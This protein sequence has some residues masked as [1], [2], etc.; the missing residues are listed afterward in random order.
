MRS[1][2]SLAGL[3]FATATIL[4]A[5]GGGG[6]SSSGS[7]SSTTPITA[8]SSA[9]SSAPSNAPSIAPS[10]SPSAATVALSG[11][12]TDFASGAPLAGL[13]VTVGPTPN[14]ST[15][16][17]AQTQTL[18]VCGTVA[19]TTATTTTNANGSF[20]FTSSQLAAGTYMMIVGNAKGSY[21]TLHRTVTITTGT[22]N[23]LGTVKLT[24][25]SSAVQSWLADVNNQR[26]TVSLPISFGNLAV[27]EYLQEEANQ[28]A[29]DVANGTTQYGDSEVDPYN[30]AYAA[31]PG[32]I[33][34]VG[35]AH[36]IGIVNYAVDPSD[37]LE[38]EDQGFM[39]EK[40]SSTGC[41]PYGGNWQTCLA[42]GDP[43]PHYVAMSYTGNVW[44]GLG[45]TSTD[46]ATLGGEPAGILFVGSGQ[47]VPAS[48]HRK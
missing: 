21:A 37:A 43:G 9:A 41:G 20:S 6:G 32:A 19:S 24:A 44:V 12:M 28:W 30:A 17:G 39:S 4:A 29:T 5:C 36:D 10:P 25:L 31:D 35:I 3:L 27:D 48:I 34:T 46:N 33:Y 2:V 1:T 15:C 38:L 22:P 7:G 26:A 23:A 47:N 16:N 13:T 11:T 42:A 18:N 45:T 14:A 8:P 40:T